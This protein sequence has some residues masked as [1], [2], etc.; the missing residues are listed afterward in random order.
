MSDIHFCLN[1]QVCFSGIAM[2]SAIAKTFKKKLSLLNVQLTNSPQQETCDIVMQQQECLW[3]NLPGQA[4][5]MDAL[6][7][8]W[9]T[10]QEG[11]P[12]MV[13]LD[14]SEAIISVVFGNSIR[15]AFAKN[16][17]LKPAKLAG[18]LFI[19]VLYCLRVCL[20]TKGSLL[21]HGAALMS[22]APRRGSL[23]LLGQ[24]GIR[25]TMITLT[26]VQRGWQ[27]VADD[28]FILHDS[29]AHRFQESLLIRD[30]HFEQLPWLVNVIAD[31]A[32]YLKYKA[33]RQRLRKLA[34]RFVPRK[35]LPNED[36][37][38][39]K[40]MQCKITNLFPE[41]SAQQIH[42]P[43]TVFIL[44][45]SENFRLKRINKAQASNDILLLQ[46]MANAE[47]NDLDDQLA[48]AGSNYVFT[49]EP[50]D[51]MKSF[52]EQQY[53]QLSIPHGMSVDAIC[54]E[55]IKCTESQ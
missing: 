47:F 29:T 4:F 38:F 41:K 55:L 2:P 51:V 25:K 19:V 53:F 34:Q 28:K 26:M 37:L 45:N 54:D 39:N 8:F 24:R 52:P 17:R 13:L 35:L 10:E 32:H 31:S 40:G 48:F 6:Y 46:R 22:N 14:K 18:K 44:K 11:K 33:W 50:G 15:I 7:G 12:T 20:Q 49:P 9:V 30:H 16:G 27:Y 36:R 43:E 1:G 21:V 5:Q 23:L 42:Q 3:P